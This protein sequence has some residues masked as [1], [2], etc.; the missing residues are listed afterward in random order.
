M[1][2]PIYDASISRALLAGFGDV[3]SFASPNNGLT[4][5]FLLSGG[6]PVPTP[7]PLGPGFGAVRPGQAVRLAPEHFSRTHLNTYAH[8]ANLSIQRQFL[9]TY[10]WEAGYTMNLAHRVGGPTVNINEIRPELRGAQ[11]NQ[12]LRPF[13]Q[14]SSISWLAPN[15]GN[16]SYHALNL[17]VEKRFSGGLN[18]LSNYTWSKFLDDVEANSEA[19][20]APGAGQQTYYARALDKSLSGN[21]VR[22]RF[23][24][25]G[26][27]E[28]PFGRGRRL[29]PGNA[30][31]DAVAG[32]WSLGA[33]VELR[34]GL[35]YGVTEA[36]N[37]LNAFSAAQRSHLT[38]DPA[39]SP[40]RPR[41]EL[42][43]GWFN[44]S[45]FAFPGDGQLGNTARNVGSGPGLVN[46]DF[47]LLKD[48]RFRE[49]R[50]LQLRGEFFNAF[51]R[52][53]FGLPNGS[54]GAAAFGRISGT[55]TEG[56]VIQIGL[57]LV[58]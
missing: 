22:H 50:Y 24:V 11:Q 46:C 21:D 55:V 25:S 39:L 41:A 18:F 16:S 6:M 57:R 48:F 8:Q 49:G 58:Y 14:Y 19:G 13:P 36:S 34:A 42:I 38:G 1:F 56:R 26:V 40:D 3:R 20:G 31:L 4:P 7:E 32:G 35:P 45:A 2:G 27:Y 44:T 43:Q 51:N 9:G 12:L 37:R 23:N 54:R 53:N 5:A 33:I 15:W 29:E 28:L 30:V 17:K 10:L 52:A 47:S